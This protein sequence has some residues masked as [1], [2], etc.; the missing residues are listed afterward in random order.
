MNKLA[1]KQLDKVLECLVNLPDDEKPFFVEIIEFISDHPGSSGLLREAW[2]TGHEEPSKILV[3][4]Q[5]NW[6][7]PEP[8]H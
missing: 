7:D 1:T 4:L 6:I 2:T 5:D 8:A 3:Y